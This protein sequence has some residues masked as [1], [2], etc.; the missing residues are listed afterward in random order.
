MTVPPADS[1]GSYPALVGYTPMTLGRRIGIVMVDMLI[2]LGAYV[3]AIVAPFVLGWR[4][5]LFVG[6]VLMVVLAVV[7]L[8][9]FFARASRLSGAFMGGVYVD[10]LTGRP[11][12]GK[13]FLK[14][15]L[16]SAISFI[17]FG[18]APMII[19]LVTAQEP[20]YRNWF[21]RTVGLMLVDT[22]TGRDPH[23][24]S[25][26][27]TQ[28]HHP[29]PQPPAASGPQSKPP[30]SA[31]LSTQ[32][33]PSNEELEHVLP[34]IGYTDPWRQPVVIEAVPGARSVA[35]AEPIDETP[36]LPHE[37]LAPD[38]SAQVFLRPTTGPAN[39]P[40]DDR[41]L[42]ATPITSARSAL[43]AFL[44]DGTVI[45]LT[46]PTVIGRNPQAPPS[47]PSARPLPV[48]DPSMELSKTHLVVGMENRTL[49]VV[50]L[51]S[52]NGVY[53]ADEP[54]GDQVRIA[55]GSQVLLA[56]GTS[57]HFGSRRIDIR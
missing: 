11:T 13:L 6:P 10:V 5:G 25:K 22:R 39:P 34:R 31:A 17:S 35:S 18:L 37:W 40:V 29:A 2:V 9:A 50:D 24:S 1:T 56:A 52:T 16:S 26:P 7:E 46:P 36:P 32:V 14:G 48:A 43:G 15:L 23:G 33:E 49:W 19:V 28:Y 21:D 3:I 44:D 20:L 30:L 42:L 41:T 57:V 47:H 27:A 45:S 54:G 38:S 55:P 8:W 12:P 4:A 51:H 53:V